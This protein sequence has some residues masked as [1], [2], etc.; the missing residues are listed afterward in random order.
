M[1]VC[2][3]SIWIFRPRFPHKV[4]P[5]QEVGWL[6]TIRISWRCGLRLEPEAGFFHSKFSGPPASKSLG[7]G[8]NA[9]FWASF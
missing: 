8:Q 6:Y 5:A 7:D 9:D 1:S 4:L 2:V 3:R